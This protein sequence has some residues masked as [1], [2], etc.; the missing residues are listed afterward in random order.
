M[1]HLKLGLRR[2]LD[3][4]DGLILEPGHAAE[5]LICD[6]GVALVLVEQLELQLCVLDEV[7]QLV[8]F[9][10]QVGQ[11]GV[12]VGVLGGEVVVLRPAP[13]HHVLGLFLHQPDALEHVGDVVDASLLYLQRLRSLVQVHRPTQRGVEEAH[14]LLGQQPERSLVASLL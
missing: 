6:V 9:G 14:E 12:E 2:R 13:V 10:F 4:H 7:V 3:G 5:V 8:L 1:W 11:V